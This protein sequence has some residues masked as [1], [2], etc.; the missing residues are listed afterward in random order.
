[1]AKP[2]IGTRND[3]NAHGI[4]NDVCQLALFVVRKGLFCKEWKNH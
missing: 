2:D 4:K 3:G 1:M